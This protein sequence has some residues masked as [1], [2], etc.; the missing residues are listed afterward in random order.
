MVVMSLLHFFAALLLNVVRSQVF[1]YIFS[2]IVSHRGSFRLF[3]STYLSKSPASNKFAMV[4]SFAF[5]VATA[6]AATCTGTKDLVVSEPQCYH[7]FSQEE[8][9]EYVYVKIADFGANGGGHMEVTGSGGII[10]E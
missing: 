1:L 2:F 10:W 8:M 4:K 9:V 6:E 3:K 7:G 5:L